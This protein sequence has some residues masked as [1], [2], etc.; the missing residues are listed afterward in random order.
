MAMYGGMSLQRRKMENNNP[1]K[2]I[3]DFTVDDKDY[4]IC[5]R[6]RNIINL[7]KQLDKHSIIK[8]L[9]DIPFN[10]NT[11]F[12]FLKFGLEGKFTDSEVEDI[13]L[14]YLEE[15]GY[16]ELQELLTSSL[17]NSGVIGKIE[18]SEK[19]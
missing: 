10:Y 13:M 3:T 11:M 14:G 6:I 16:I 5:Y 18:G 15:N 2:R 8:E 17:M 12:L 7:E 9:T 1:L 19:N 4:H